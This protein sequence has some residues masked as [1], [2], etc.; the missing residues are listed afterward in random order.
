MRPLETSFL[1]DKLSGLKRLFFSGQ[2]DQEGPSLAQV[3]ALSE[4]IDSDNGGW[5]NIIE[6]E[7]E[8]KYGAEHLVWLNEVVHKVPNW[9]GIFWQNMSL[10]AANRDLSKIVER[11]IPV[12]PT[13]VVASPDIFVNGVRREVAY[14]IDQHYDSEG[15][16]MTY[17]D[18][19]DIFEIRRELLKFARMGIELQKEGYG[20][21]LLGG[22]IIGNLIHPKAPEDFKIA[23]LLVSDRE[24]VARRDWD[25]CGVKSGDVFA[26]PKEALLCDTRLYDFTP[27]KG[28]KGRSVLRVM[29]LFQDSQDAILWGILKRFGIMP[30]I[31]LQANATRRAAIKLLNRSIPY[32]EGKT[33][34]P[35]LVNFA[36]AS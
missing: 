24:R 2:L 14:R 30:E 22:Q 13:E 28:I 18:V 6:L 12:I 5:D 34:E 4:I 29:R 3:M 15:R 10:S 23:N 7:G 26:K 36:E 21:D 27:Q 17:Q 9:F 32:M 31:D 8:K 25:Q 11:G 1:D 20:L 35:P 19:A 33:D 16:Q